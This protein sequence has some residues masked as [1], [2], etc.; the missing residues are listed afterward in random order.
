M[1]TSLFSPTPPFIPSL[2]Q[3]RPVAPAFIY[4]AAAND[5]PAAR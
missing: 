4:F 2:R 5:R 3:S 1:K